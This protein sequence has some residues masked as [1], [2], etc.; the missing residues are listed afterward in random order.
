M[1]LGFAQIRA[2]VQEEVREAL[3][4][5]RNPEGRMDSIAKCLW[6]F[7]RSLKKTCIDGRVGQLGEH[8]LCK[9]ARGLQT[10]YRFLPFSFIYNNLGHLLFAQKLTPTA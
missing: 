3:G 8:L 4:A 5:F 2:V 6:D 1:A 10:L 9:L 7:T